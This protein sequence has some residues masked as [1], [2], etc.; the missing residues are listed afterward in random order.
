MKRSLTLL[1]GYP[2]IIAPTFAETMVT[3]GVMMSLEDPQAQREKKKDHEN[4]GVPGLLQNVQYLCRTQARRWMSGA[5]CC[6]ER[7]VKV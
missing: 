6:V 2:V 7:C 1:S 4:K 5:E 3:E